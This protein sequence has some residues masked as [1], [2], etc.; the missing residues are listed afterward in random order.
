MANSFQQLGSTNSL[1]D[2]TYIMLASIAMKNLNW[3]FAII[4]DSAIIARTKKTFGSWGEEISIT[5]DDNIVTFRSSCIQWQI[6]DW[7]KN[8]KKYWTSN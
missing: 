6:I 3:D 2:G 1:P 4:G 7:G 8:K 5:I